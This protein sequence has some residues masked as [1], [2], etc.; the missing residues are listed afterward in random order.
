[1]K[2]ILDRSHT[3]SREQNLRHASYPELPDLMLY[4]DTHEVYVLSE[5]APV[6][7]LRDAPVFSGGQV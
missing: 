3:F 7:L 4:A 2:D 1:M 5:V 6:V